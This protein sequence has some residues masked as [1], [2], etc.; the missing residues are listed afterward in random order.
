M[1]CG[2]V[3]GVAYG[4]CNRR[5]YRANDISNT[6]F[7]LSIFV[8]GNVFCGWACPVG[9]IIDSFDKGVERFMPKLNTK[10]E[11]RFQRSIEKSKASHSSAVCPM[12]PLR[13]V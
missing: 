11:E 10:R 6:F 5:L 13:R 3:A 9:T 2:R 4:V 8:L 1:P 12:C 7:L